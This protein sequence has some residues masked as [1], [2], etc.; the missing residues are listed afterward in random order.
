VTS[1]DG[2]TP[3]DDSETRYDVTYHV[4]ASAPPPWAN[5]AE[6]KTAFPK[7]AQDTSAQQMTSA[8]LIKTANGWQVQNVQ[9]GAAPASSMP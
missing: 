9:P 6:M 8:S 4:G 1:I 3:T 7:L 5:S 2:Y